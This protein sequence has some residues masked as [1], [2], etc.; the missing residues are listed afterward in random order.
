MSSSLF[1]VLN[2]GDNIPVLQMDTSIVNTIINQEDIS[3]HQSIAQ[4]YI[5]SE[6]NTE[7]KVIEFKNRKFIRFFNSIYRCIIYIHVCTIY[8]A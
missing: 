3:N 8:C 4:K 5:I 6:T 7:G 1:G 2:C